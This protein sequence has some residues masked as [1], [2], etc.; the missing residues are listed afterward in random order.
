V[1]SQVGFHFA[2]QLLSRRNIATGRLN[3]WRES[4]DPSGAYL[5]TWRLVCDRAC[6]C[7]STRHPALHVASLRVNSCERIKWSCPSTV[8]ASAS[9]WYVS[10]DFTPLVLC[11][12][13]FVVFT[14]QE[15]VL[16][17]T[18]EKCEDRTR[19]PFRPALQSNTYDAF[20]RHQWRVSI[21][22]YIRAHPGQMP[23]TVINTSHFGY[24]HGYGRPVEMLWVY[25][26][27]S[28]KCWRHA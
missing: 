15:L 13:S 24:V 8:A 2:T 1:A 22:I 9:T 12:S 11:V 21:G 18:C 17:G 25:Q 3:H 27:W 10:F 19:Y 4:D 28:F 26:R 16:A 7:I 6:A 23:S 14:T 20:D 5:S